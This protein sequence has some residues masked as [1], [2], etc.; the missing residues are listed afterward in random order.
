MGSVLLMLTMMIC[1]SL[2]R[3][4]CYN[5]EKYRILENR[6][7]VVVEGI[8]HHMKDNIFLYPLIVIVL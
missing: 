5:M 7:P 3:N 1:N 6:S 8:I 2:K 4:R